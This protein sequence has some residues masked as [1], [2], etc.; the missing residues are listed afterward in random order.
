MLIFLLLLGRSPS[1]TDTDVHRASSMQQQCG[2]KWRAWTVTALLGNSDSAVAIGDASR[3][4][5]GESFLQSNGK[6]QQFIDCRA[7]GFQTNTCTR[8]RYEWKYTVLFLFCVLLVHGEPGNTT[9]WDQSCV[10]NPSLISN[11][12]LLQK[13]GLN[14]EVTWL[15]RTCKTQQIWISVLI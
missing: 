4:S 14:S 3:L 10:Q 11:Q 1:N 7:A 13:S 6:H 12:S 15:C 2:N 8:P 5:R 9:S